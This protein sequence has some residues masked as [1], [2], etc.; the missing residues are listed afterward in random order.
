MVPIPLVPP[1]T[2]TLS[3]SRTNELEPDG[4][5][6][7]FVGNVGFSLT[8]ESPRPTSLGRLTVD[9]GVE[10]AAEDLVCPNGLVTSADGRRL[11]VAET[12]RDRVTVFTIDDAGRLT[13]RAVAV[14]LEAGARPDG[15]DVDD[16]GRI[17]VARMDRAEVT[18]HRPDGSVD[19]AVQT[20]QPAYACRLVGDHGD[21]LVVCTS[22]GL[23]PEELDRRPGSVELADLRGL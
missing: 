8:K 15:I 11:Y 23:S 4:R 14:Q 17:W 6:G 2:S 20:S 21:R 7:Y 13:E 19:L 12:Y 1:W 3:P 5:G 16:L 10:V 18:R 22:S 9:G